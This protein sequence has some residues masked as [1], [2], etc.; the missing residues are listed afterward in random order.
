[1]PALTK[2][3]E[4][5]PLTGSVDHSCKKRQRLCKSRSSPY[6]R[7][8]YLHTARS[9]SS[10]WHRVRVLSVFHAKKVIPTIV[11]IPSLANGVVLSA[12]SGLLAALATPPFP[13]WPLIF[14]AFVPMIVAQHRIL[15]S[16][17]SVLAPGITLGLW[18]AS[19]L[20]EGLVEAGVPF[21][22]QLLPLYAGLIAAVLSWRT[23]RFHQETSYRWFFAA[24][25]VAWVAIDFLR[26]QE[27][28]MLAGTW[29]N[30]VYALWSQPWLLQPVSL[31]GT[32]GLEL[33]LMGNWALAGLVIAVLD[34]RG[35]PP[36]YPFPSYRA[37]HWY[38]E[39]SRTGFLSSRPTGCGTPWRLIPG[40]EL[41]PAWLIGTG[42]AR[43]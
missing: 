19:Q 40:V 21:A 2:L 8:L 31:A 39:R 42:D 43:H 13:L 5:A 23:R 6:V 30:P 15:P 11:E 37:L 36:L 24:T 9:L 25:A 28:A 22:F 20:L 3:N 26:G 10:H 14:L 41:L 7:L 4:R 16:R 12:L 38:F 33:L 18:F 34:K 29:G 17:W 1:M 27:V 35:T 32:Y